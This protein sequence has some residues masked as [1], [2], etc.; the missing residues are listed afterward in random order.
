MGRCDVPG[1]KRGP[2][3]KHA[4]STDVMRADDHGLGGERE[5]ERERERRER[6]REE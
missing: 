3:C 1:K 4:D 2:T 6:R 5:R